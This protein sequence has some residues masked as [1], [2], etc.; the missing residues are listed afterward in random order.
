MY[1]VSN[2]PHKPSCTVPWNLSWF[3]TFPHLCIVQMGKLNSQMDTCNIKSY[4][5]LWFH[6]SPVS[7]S[8]PW[9][10][11]WC[12]RPHLGR[13]STTRPLLGSIKTIGD[14]VEVI[15]FFLG[16]RNGVHDI[17]LEA[18]LENLGSRRTLYI[19]IYIMISIDKLWY[20]YKKHIKLTHPSLLSPIF[21]PSQF[22]ILSAS[23]EAEIL[24]VGLGSL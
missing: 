17:P 10:W 3:L 6:E 7:S 2:S 19:Y 18:P 16:L 15:R 24:G 1:I 21:V 20:I 5:T 14:V 9:K 13:T 22:V 4:Q 8:C 12:Q 23:S 11:K